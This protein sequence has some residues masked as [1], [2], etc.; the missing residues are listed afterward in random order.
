M[1]TLQLGV[2]SFQHLGLEFLATMSG[3]GPTGLDSVVCGVAERA[4]SGA[5]QAYFY[6]NPFGTEHSGMDPAC[7]GTDWIG[8]R[9]KEL[10]GDCSSVMTTNLPGLLLYISRK[11]APTSRNYSHDPLGNYHSCY[12]LVD[13]VVVMGTFGQLED[14][15]FQIVESIRVSS[16]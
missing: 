4:P 14:E 5:L 8:E 6:L 10:K 1:D 3:T 2:Q 13:S 16:I 7:A 11:G 9:T 15:R 12:I